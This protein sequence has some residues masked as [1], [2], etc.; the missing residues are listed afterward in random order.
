VPHQFKLDVE[1]SVT[2]YPVLRKENP[3]Q[4]IDNFLGENFYVLGKKWKI[5]VL[6]HTSCH[7]LH[8]ETKN[9][10]FGICLSENNVLA[11]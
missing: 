4:Y 7:W 5:E 2:G 6:P 10:M 3:A 11:G 1:F 9:I 8:R